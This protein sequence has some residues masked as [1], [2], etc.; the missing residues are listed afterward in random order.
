MTDI[1]KHISLTRTALALVATSC[2][3][4]AQGTDWPQWG[5]DISR[6]M[7]S[8]DK[9]VCGDFK[10]GR[11]VG[12]SDKIDF[13]TT[14]NVKW[15]AKLGSQTYGNPTVA[16]GRDIRRNEQ[17]LV[18]ATS[19]SSGDRIRAS[20]AST[21]RTGEP[22]LAA[23]RSE[24]RYGQSERLGVPRHLLVAR[25]GRRPRL[26]RRRTAARSSVVDVNGMADG[27]DGPYQDEGLSTWP[28]P[29][30]PS[31]WR[32]RRPTPTSSGSRT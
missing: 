8:P 7:V 21:R 19:A 26:P 10:A 2:V 31:R 24:A 27:N 16:G 22:H 11:F 25:R 28:W 14:K 3:A 23:Q 4:F 30:K 9:N 32:S 20:T 5:R 6:N 18:R 12:T 13:K 17:R 15:I 29:A 1:R